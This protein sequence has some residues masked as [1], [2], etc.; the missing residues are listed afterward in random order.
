MYWKGMLYRMK[1]LYVSLVYGYKI[2]LDYIFIQDSF[3]GYLY[4]FQ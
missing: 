3:G 2:V 4:F 1:Q